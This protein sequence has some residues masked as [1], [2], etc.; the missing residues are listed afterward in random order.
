MIR[1]VPSLSHEPY[2]RNRFSLIIR[3]D[4]KGDSALCYRAVVNAITRVNKG[5][6][7]RCPTLSNRLL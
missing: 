2:Q 3:G 1:L 6:T 5:G 7:F 4:N